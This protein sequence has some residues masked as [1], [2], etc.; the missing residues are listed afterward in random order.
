MTYD[1]SEFCIHLPRCP[2]IEA[3]NNLEKLA[4]GP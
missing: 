2:T 1:T 3:C 4:G